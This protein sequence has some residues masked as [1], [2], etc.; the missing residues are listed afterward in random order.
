M[1]SA[2]SNYYFDMDNEL[3]KLIDSADM[4]LFWP[5]DWK[6]DCFFSRTNVH[7]HILAGA[8][9]VYQCRLAH[10]FKA[11]RT[12]TRYGDPGKKCGGSV[13][14]SSNAYDSQTLLE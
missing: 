4:L 2:I 11:A 1:V 14:Y 5:S 9:S 3:Y 8:Y 6:S 7:V 12:T 13:G 10:Q